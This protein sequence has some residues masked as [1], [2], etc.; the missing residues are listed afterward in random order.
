MAS[1]GIQK[2]LKRSGSISFWL[3][4]CRENRDFEL[5][6][7]GRI[8]RNCVELHELRRCLPAAGAARQGALQRILEGVAEVTI[9]VRIDEW[10]QGTVEVT[11]PE[12]HRYN[13]V[14]AI[15]GLAAQ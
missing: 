7:R 3:E 11:Y 8:F 15:A 10:I 4:I 2:S 14:R 13:R 12:E 1:I 9:E 5:A 6:F